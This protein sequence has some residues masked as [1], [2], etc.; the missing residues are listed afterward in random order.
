MLVGTKRLVRLYLRLDRIT[1]PAT[2]FLA[3]AMVAGSAPA[4]VSAYPDYT[5][6]LAYVASSVTSV[7]GRVFQGT[8]QGVSL[9]SI[10]MAETF[11]FTAVILAIMS[12]FIVSRHT[13]Y[14]E[15]TGASELI[16][17]MQVGRNS[18]LT[19]ALIVAVGANVV[20]GLLIFLSLLTVPELEKTGSLYFAM[21]LVMTGIFF[22]GVS[23]ITVQLSDFDGER[24]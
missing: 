17:S 24:I 5:T 14:D 19:G 6:Q 8:I 16:E 21:S 10:L 7:V 23:A 20:A 1:I 11:I 4:L 13:R 3:I 2:L 18:S 9:G 22:A 15:E 12:I